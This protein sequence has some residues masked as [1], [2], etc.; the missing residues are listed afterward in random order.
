MIDLDERLRTL[1]RF[2]APDLWAEVEIRA[3]VPLLVPAPD[4][5]RL[6]P[7]FTERRWVAAVVAFAVFAAAGTL[8]V[9]RLRFGESTAPAEAPDA[10]LQAQRNFAGLVTFR[11]SVTIDYGSEEQPAEASFEISYRLP[12][13]RE[14]LT[15]EA[16]AGLGSGAVGDVGVSN[17]REGSYLGLSEAPLPEGFV[18]ARDLSPATGPDSTAPT[19]TWSEVCAAPGSS[20]LADED[21]AG[22]TAWR[23][24]CGP[25]DGPEPNGPWDLWIDAE[26]G[27]ILRVDGPLVPEQEFRPLGCACPSTGFRVTAFDPGVTFDP[28]VFQ[29]G[30]GRVDDPAGVS[31]TLVFDRVTPQP[32]GVFDGATIATLQTWAG[33][34]LATGSVEG[35][36]GLW[37]WVSPDGFVWERIRPEAFGEEA[38]I[39]N[40]IASG[41]P[42]LVAFVGGVEE[43]PSLWVSQDA[44]TWERVPDD[45]EVFGPRSRLQDVE[46][47]GPGIVAIGFDPAGP[48]RFVQAVW[49]SPDGRSWTEVPGIAE[50]FD[51][52]TLITV[53]QSGGEVIGWED[54]P[55]AAG[56]ATIWTTDDGVA[57]RRLNFQPRLEDNGGNNLPAVGGPGFVVPG[58]DADFTDPAV[59][60]S[61]DGETWTKVPYDEAVFELEGFQPYPSAIPGGPGVVMWATDA[62]GAVVW[63]SRDGVTWTRLPYDE[64]AFGPGTS[65]GSIVQTDRGVIAIGTDS[66]GVAVWLGRP[67]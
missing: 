59:W 18:P 26:T 58:V 36:A 46:A 5:R 61:P 30:P 8:V 48:N 66:S 34:L 43:R 65:I 4:R 22:R 19:V 47:A 32:S 27:A 67:A 15:A 41:E 9:G 20:V 10:I 35:E 44:R 1:D 29:V 63:T 2:E 54:D 55:S 11:A 16:P 50:T 31:N 12:A 23:L 56:V 13:Y 28:A 37:M 33:G 57:W 64:V 45:L 7:R 62:W 24:R 52:R 3:S 40:G 21:V 14:V 38:F 60:T 53:Y 25:L 39:V 51:G 49:T 42:G 17:G 6:L